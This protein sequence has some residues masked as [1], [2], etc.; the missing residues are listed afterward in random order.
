MEVKKMQFRNTPIVSTYQIYLTMVV[1]FPGH[2]K[3]ELILYTC[4]TESKHMEV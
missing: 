3:T 1:T 2:K 4:M